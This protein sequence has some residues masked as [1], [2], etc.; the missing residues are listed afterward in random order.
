MSA[1]HLRGVKTPAGRDPDAIK[2][3]PPVPKHLTPF[4]AKEWDRVLPMLIRRGLICQADLGF[5][6]AYCVA[7]GLI[8]EAELRRRQKGED[9]AKWLRTQNAAMLT[10]ARLSA[11]LGLDPSSRARLLDKDADEDDGDDPLAVR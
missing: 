10:A 8:V 3:K 1:T 9:M 11:S 7:R 2:R 4:A 5:V 6:E